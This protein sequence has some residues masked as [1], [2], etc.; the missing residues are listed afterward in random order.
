M[1]QSERGTDIKRIEETLLEAIREDD[2]VLI[3]GGGNGL[4]RI[5]VN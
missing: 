1:D 4:T 2:Y 3:E 5:E